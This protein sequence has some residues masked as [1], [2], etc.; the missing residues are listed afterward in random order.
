MTPNSQNKP[1][2]KRRWRR[3]LLVL[4]GLI[5]A[6][7]VGFGWWANRLEAEAFRLAQAGRDAGKVLGGFAGALKDKD[8][9]AALAF[10]DD[11]YRHDQQGLWTETLRREIDGARIYD[12]RMR[13]PGVFTKGDMAEQLA[14]LTARFRS[15]ELAKFKLASVERL[16][17]DGGLTVRGTLWLRG[18][19]ADGLL[20][21]RKA[22]FR[23]S[24]VRRDGGPAPHAI[25]RLDFLHGETVTGEGVGFNDVAASV[26]LDF[27]GF[28]NPHFKTEEWF[29]HKFY[30]AQYSSA[31][32]SAA[33]YD[34][35]GW[36]DLFFA[37]GARA[38]LY[39]NR[40]GRF[41]D[42]T[43]A[44]GLPDQLGAVN[45]A[46]FAD[47]DNDGDQD[48]F[49]SRFTRENLLFRNEGDG[50]FVNVTD[51]AGLGRNIVAT[52][53]AGDYDNDGDLDL[54]LG[55]YLD[56]RVDLPTTLFYSRNSQGNSLLRNDG[57]LRFTDVAEEAG[58]REGGLSLGVAW[59]DLDEDGDQDLY[60]ANDYGRN[61]LFLNRG[62]GSFEDVALAH[63]AE[64]LG[65][66]MSADFGDVD[67]DGDL[68]IY[69]ANVHSGQRWYG[70]APTFKNYLITSFKQG[71]F[72][73]DLPIYREIYQHLGPAWAS[74][75]D[76]L[77]KGNTLLLND[78]A[79]HFE[80]V[81][82]AARANPFGWYWGS[83]FLDYDNDG[84]QDIYT[85][86]GWI[87]AKS[88]DD[89]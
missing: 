28:R 76:H 71:T 23:V 84:W 60:V 48:L 61:A 70:H 17:D 85:A 79:G 25:D 46:L 21:E 37:D 34:G 78:G 74:A 51:G 30:I 65:F 40:G 87:T 63:G 86:N 38:R 69:I 50:S 72:F 39:R 57:D 12:W 58:V 5:L 88:H 41:E 68:D 52:A 35:D 29:P 54:Y 45:T 49:L 10:V 16:H 62:D 14:A 7:A 11:G 73:E 59:G 36:D 20:F 2:P 42:V 26:G 18:I 55:R 1:K 64:D 27:R 43:V 44:A 22:A 75:G 33:D 83:V 32:V 19:Q 67:N 9:D 4:L 15:V 13:D 89:Y 47:F 77:V 82:V 31:G 80:D 6:V 81:S 24:L 53:A 66:G 8:P 3:R 56:P